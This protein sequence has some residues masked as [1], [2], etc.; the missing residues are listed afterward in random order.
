MPIEQVPRTLTPDPELPNAAT[1]DPEAAGNQ[2]H[3]LW[4]W[5]PR[6]PA[7]Q[8]RL[9]ARLAAVGDRRLGR[10]PGSTGLARNSAMPSRAGQAGDRLARIRTSSGPGLIAQL[11]WPRLA[12]AA[13]PWDWKFPWLTPSSISCSATIGRFAESRLQLTPVEWGVWSYLSFGP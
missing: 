5:L 6:L 13:W 8:V 9:E 1:P 11:R 2:T 3:E 10:D 12:D 7:R 4:S